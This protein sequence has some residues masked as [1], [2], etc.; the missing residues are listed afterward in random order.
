MP[1]AGRFYQNKD[2]SHTLVDWEELKGHF[3]EDVE[4]AK[5]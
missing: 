2:E 3:I 5:R 1:K 4:D